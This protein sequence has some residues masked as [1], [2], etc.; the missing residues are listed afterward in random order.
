MVLRRG[1]TLIEIMVTISIIAILAG[2]IYAS[3]GDARE[4]ARNKSMAVELKEMQLAIETYRS[5][6]NSYPLPSTDSAPC[7]QTSSGEIFATDND[8]SDGYIEGLAPEYIAELVPASNSMND[9]CDI[10]YRTD[11]NGSWYKLTAINCLAGMDASTGTTENKPLARCSTT[12]SASGR[13]NPNNSNYY[14]S[15]AVYS[16]GGQCQ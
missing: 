1:F 5:Q 12:C 10:E 14:Q 9:A 11:T 3:F 8:C 7:R 13:C 16:L 4:S 2:V 15:L 6:N